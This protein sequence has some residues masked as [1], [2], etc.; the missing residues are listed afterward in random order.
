MSKDQPKVHSVKYNLIM[1]AILNGTQVLFPVITFPYI[2][3]VLGAEGNG[4]VSFAASVAYYFMMVASLGIPTYGVRACAKVRDDRDELSKNVQELLAIGSAM[5]VL[6]SVMY[7][8][9]VLLIPRF[10]Q[11]KMLFYINGIN[12]ILNI[13]GANWVYQALEQYDYITARSV[14]FKLVSLVLMFA[15]VH[16]PGDYVIYGAILVVATVGSN[17]F[18]LFRLRKI[19]SFKRYEGYD[20]KRHLKPVF[21]LFAQSLAISVYTNLDTVMLG[22]MKTDVDVGYYNAAVK[23]KTVLVSVVASLGSVLL[24]RMSYYA[25]GKQM[26]KFREYVH[27]VINVELLMAVPVAVYF[28]IFAREVIAFLAGAGYEGAILPMQIITVTVIPIGL[29]N[30]LGIQVLTSLEKE[31][32][33]L[34]SVVCGA[35]VDFVLNLA[36][37]P[38]FSASGAALATTIT[39]FVVLIVQVYYTKDLLLEIRDKITAWRYV[40][41]GLAAGGL[42]IVAR[43]MG[44]GTFITLFVSA[45]VYFGIYLIGLVLLKEPVVLDIAG[46]IKGKI[47]SS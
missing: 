31:V 26:D 28:T 2:S 45:V 34:R 16:Q 46:W 27:K 22:F 35:I 47:H 10:A 12:I 40:I 32:Y 3:R 6:V 14:F 11:E 5:T 21:T 1:N 36:L 44:L 4:K 24:P 19:I 23:V 8:F 13:F 38:G 39:E 33:V 30:I 7:F 9:C 42:S 43:L 15:L 41:L 17:L 29:T 20:L 18:N 37:I 25:A